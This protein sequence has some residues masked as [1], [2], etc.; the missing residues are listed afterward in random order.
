[1]VLPPHTGVYDARLKLPARGR[2]GPLFL[3]T[4]HTDK[5]SGNSCQSLVTGSNLCWTY[6][7]LSGKM[8]RT[9]HDLLIDLGVY[10]KAS[11]DRLLVTIVT[12]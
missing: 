5:K 11:G 2:D 1:M 4:E 6:V 3:V 8:R 9:S 7:H 12:S 10:S